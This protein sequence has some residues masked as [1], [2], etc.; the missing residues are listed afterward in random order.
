[1]QKIVPFLW[2][3]GKAEEAAKFYV[4]IFKNSKVMSVTPGPDG[5]AMA[6]TFQL[7]GRPSMR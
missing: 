3:D 6:V 2:F 1:M 4:S 7:E 5:T